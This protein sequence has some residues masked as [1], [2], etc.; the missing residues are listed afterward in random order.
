LDLS[1]IIVNYNVQAMLEQTLLSVYKAIGNLSVEVIVVDNHSADDSCGMVREKFKQVI[2]IENKDNVGFSKANNQGILIAKGKNVL[3]LN[4]DTVLSEDSLFKTNGYLNEHA[5]VGALGVRMIDGRGVFL[6]ESKRGLPTPAVAFYKMSGLASLFP[7]SKVFGAYHL[8]F[9]SEFETN[10][11]DVLSGAF[12][13]I[14]K[15]VLD[16]VGFL[17]ENF[18]MYGEDIDLSYRIQKGGYKNIYFADTTIIHYK[19]ES[20]K[21]HSVNYVKIFYQ[22]MAKFA[23]KHFSKSQG[24]WFTF[25][26]NTAILIRA[27]IALLNR[28]VNASKLLILDYVLIFAGFFGLMR[29][30]E[31]YNKYV[32]GGFYPKEYIQYHVPVYIL[33]WV[34]GITI[35]GGY[36]FPFQISKTSRGVIFGSFLLLTV[37]ALLPES[38][39]FSRA[40]ILLGSVWALLIT[41]AIRLFWHFIKYKHFDT[42]VSQTSQVLIVGDL[43]ECQRVKNILLNYPQRFKLLGFIKP[44]HVA[45]KAEWLGSFENLPLL[46]EIY[47]A[48]EIIFC[49]KDIPG[50]EI[51]ELM[52]RSHNNK[53]KYKIMPEKGAY[54]IGSNSKNTTGEFFSI[55]MTP[56]LSNQQIKNKKRLFDFLIC[57]I[58]PFLLPVLLFRWR[59]LI[60]ILKNWLHCLT[61]KKSWI[62]YNQHAVTQNLPKIKPGVFKVNSFYVD[63]IKDEQLLK[64]I[65][66][67]YA[68][69]YHWQ[70][71]LNMLIKAFFSNTFAS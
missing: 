14:K 16:E 46:I 39:R 19:G 58:L 50:T 42:T 3:L 66:L 24:K 62:G 67:M 20:T 26:I 4:P 32:V 10:E 56:A 30:W 12:M 33:F 51:M 69:H 52:G 41:I 1:V 6:P 47:N 43:E 25:F 53:V 71:D 54:I 68:S 45:T 61:G 8:S 60:S 34:S 29:Y 7:K 37:Y 48:N 11:V 55:D 44:N 13:M 31:I 70:N 27:S 15:S 65:N 22:A 23:T 28:V 63:E 59:F 57:M 36:L 49:S 18:F 21:K 40:L 5:E 38:M 2:L 64:N 17:D 35:S 9:L